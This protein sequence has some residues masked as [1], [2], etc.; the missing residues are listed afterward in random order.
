MAHYSELVSIFS[1]NIELVESADGVHSGYKGRAG[2]LCDNICL[3]RQRIAV[4]FSDVVE[5][6]DVY[7]YSTL[8]A[9]G[10]ISP[11]YESRIAKT[12][13][14]RSPVKLSLLMKLIEGDVYEPSILRAQW[15]YLISFGYSAWLEVGVHSSSGI[16]T[17]VSAS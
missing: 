9:G 7:Y 5:A 6:S 11:D 14:L 16:S 2:N 17:V 13:G 1:L 12:G 4:A 8:F 10:S 3:Q 15:V